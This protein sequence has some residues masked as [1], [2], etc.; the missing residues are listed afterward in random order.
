MELNQKLRLFEYGSVLT[1]VLVVLV[2]VVVLDRA[3]AHLRK[4]LV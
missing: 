2:V 1:I 3:S 4:R